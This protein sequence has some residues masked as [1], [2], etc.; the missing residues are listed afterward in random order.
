MNQK[1]KIII[2]W[3]QWDVAIKTPMIC[4]WQLE[5]KSALEELEVA[6]K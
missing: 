5:H 6:N 1:L 2:D 3:I 4:Q